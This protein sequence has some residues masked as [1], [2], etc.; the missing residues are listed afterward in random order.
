MSR[1]KNAFT[2]TLMQECEKYN[3]FNIIESELVNESQQFINDEEMWDIPIEDLFEWAYDKFEYN[4]LDSVMN[5]FRNI[6]AKTIYKEC[7]DEGVSIDELVYVLQLKHRPFKQLD[8]FET[9]SDIQY[10]LALGQELFN[11]RIQETKKSE[12]NV[13][14]ELSI[15]NIKTYCKKNN[16]YSEDGYLNCDCP[17]LTKGGACSLTNALTFLPSSWKD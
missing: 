6:L 11:D 16:R 5:Q 8:D 13:I 10:L 17:C 2:D 4:Y 7:V 9:E 15:N 1:L 14:L 12:D 3:L